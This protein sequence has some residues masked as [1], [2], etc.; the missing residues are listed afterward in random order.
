MQITKTILRGGTV[1]VAAIVFFF[2]GSSK[3]MAGDI[4][5]LHEFASGANDGGVPESSLIQSDTTLYGMT[6]QGGDDYSGT[7]FSV[8]TNGTNFSLLHEFAG[9]GN[10]GD[11]P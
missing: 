3:T 2:F 6:T 9:G 7:I 1:L 11:T 8:Q 4:T 10:D 5:L